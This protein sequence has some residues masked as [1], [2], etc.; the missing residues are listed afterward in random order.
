ME[1]F[2][3]IAVE[4]DYPNGLT[5]DGYVCAAFPDEEKQVD[6]FIVGLISLAGAPACALLQA[7][8]QLHALFIAVLS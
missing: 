6:S 2:A 5:A 7:G 4:P 1:Q 8:K 3:D